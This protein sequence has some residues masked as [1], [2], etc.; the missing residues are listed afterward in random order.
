MINRY[1]KLQNNC[2]NQYFTLGEDILKI[3]NLGDQPPE[4]TAIGGG[5][6]NIGYNKND[7]KPSTIA[8]IS[9]D[10][11]SFYEL[12]QIGRSKVDYISNMFY[13][14]P[15]GS[16]IWKLGREANAQP[17]LQ[18]PQ[19]KT[20]T[21][22]PASTHLIIDR[23]DNKKETI[24]TTNTFSGDDQI[25]GTPGNEEMNTGNGKDIIPKLWGRYN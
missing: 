17:L 15:K 9:I 6:I 8:E 25:V 13:E 5:K 22:G 11:E 14:S 10:R 24:F 1:I 2:S 20:Y 18:L 7:G 3:Q 16:G 23:G 4:I 21:G 19:N 12:D